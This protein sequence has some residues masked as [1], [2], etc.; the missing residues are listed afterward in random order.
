MQ[1]AT[2]TAERRTIASLANQYGVSFRTLRLYEEQ[3]LLHPFRRGQER[4]YSGKDEVRLQL[5]LKGKRLGFTLNEIR[6]LIAE[7]ATDRAPALEIEREDIVEILD[8]RT[9]E[10]QT[11]HLEQRKV[12]IDQ[13]IAE[14]RAA[15]KTMAP[16]SSVQPSD[17]GATVLPN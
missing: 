14:L 3:G 11:E 1:P 5:I 6:Q 17:R 9:I 7:A 8:V 12:Q 10:R 15:L 2:V 13:A 16:A 4:L